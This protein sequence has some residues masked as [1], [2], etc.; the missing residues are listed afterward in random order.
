M[1]HKT[2]LLVVLLILPVGTF[3]VCLSWLHTLSDHLLL[4]GILKLAQKEKLHRIKI[5]LSLETQL[6]GGLITSL[7][8]TNTVGYLFLILEMELFSVSVWIP[9]EVPDFLLAVATLFKICKSWKTKITL[10]SQHMFTSRR[11][12]K[13]WDWLSSSWSHL[14]MTHARD[15]PPYLKL[16]FSHSFMCQCAS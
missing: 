12:W 5:I 16:S 1:A 9:S 4:H 10:S 11:G 6:S 3:F 13:S 15:F 14:R 2:S 7:L 8:E